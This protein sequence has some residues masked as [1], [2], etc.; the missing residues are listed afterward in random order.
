MPKL[1]VWRKQS[2][3][4]LYKKGDVIS[5]IAEDQDFSDSEVADNHT[6]TIDVVGVT[7]AKCR[8]LLEKERRP[9]VYGD[10]EYEA[11]DASDKWILTG[12]NKW[13]FTSIADHAIT[14]D[15]LDA[16]LTN[17][18]GNDLFSTKAANTYG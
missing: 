4:A 11:P 8:Q 1:L 13:Y 5:V 10:P 15:E 14:P 12:Q 17:R 16:A 18:E 7:L 9:A 2:A 3:T 6:T